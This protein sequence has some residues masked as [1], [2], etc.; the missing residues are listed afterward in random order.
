MP[1]SAVLID[2]VLIPAESV[3]TAKGDSP[4]VEISSAAT[5]AFLLEL[6]ISNVTEQECMELSLLGSADGTAWG[7]Q[8]LAT[9]P[10]RFYPAEY[11]SLVDLSAEPV[12]NFLKVHWEVTRWGRGDQVPRFVCGATLREVPA[13]LLK[14]FRQDAEFRKA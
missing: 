2:S 8:P 5:R 6:K 11:P 7:P 14:E 12:V 1:E 13:E 9:F 4:V 10:Q 3:L